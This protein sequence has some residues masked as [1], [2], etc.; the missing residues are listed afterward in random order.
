MVSFSHDYL[1]DINNHGWKIVLQVLPQSG[2]CNYIL[3]VILLFSRLD[4]HVLSKQA[5]SDLSNVTCRMERKNP[6]FGQC[7][8]LGVALDPR[9]KKLSTLIDDHLAPLAPLAPRTLWSKKRR[10]YQQAREMIIVP[11]KPF[12]SSN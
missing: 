3:G 10:R 6:L 11:R 12:H 1:S 4:R 9:F 2:L 7:V 5:F 8:G